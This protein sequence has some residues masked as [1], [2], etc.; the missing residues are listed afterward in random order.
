MY[1]CMDVCVCVCIDWRMCLCHPRLVSKLSIETYMCMSSCLFI[2]VPYMYTLYIHLYCMTLY[3]TVYSVYSDSVQC[4]VSTN[5]SDVD[6]SEH[7]PHTPEDGEVLQVST[8]ER[9]VRTELNLVMLKQSLWI[10]DHC[11]LHYSLLKRRIYSW[12]Q[13]NFVSKYIGTDYW[14]VSTPHSVPT[15]STVQSNLVSKYL[16]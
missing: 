15:S 9:R 16:G 1:L 6:T 4:T 14:M 12:V 10:W 7:T 3:T 2:H 11:E 13:S 8:C 5:G